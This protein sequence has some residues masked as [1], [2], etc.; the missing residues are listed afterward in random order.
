[1]I[2]IEKGDDR[3]LVSFPYNPEYVKRIKIIKGRR[4]HPEGKYWSFP[5]T[6]GTLERILKVFEGEE[7]SYKKLSF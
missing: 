5:N 3:V 2:R 7:I 1:M 4:W 6:N